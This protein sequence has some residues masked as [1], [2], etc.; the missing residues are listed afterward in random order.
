M[1]ELVVGHFLWPGR[2]DG[3]NVMGTCTQKKHLLDE[4]FQD[5]YYMISQLL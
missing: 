2:S 3:T 5:Q 1:E 4:G